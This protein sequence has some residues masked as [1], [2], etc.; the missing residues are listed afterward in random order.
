MSLNLAITGTGSAPKPKPLAGFDISS[1]LNPSPKPAPTS[2][3]FVGGVGALPSSTSSQTNFSGWLNQNTPKAN[4]TTPVKKVTTSSP[5][6]HTQTI[7][8]HAPQSNDTKTG[9]LGSGGS[10]TQNPG[11]TSQNGM[12]PTTPTTIPTT[13]PGLVGSLAK[14]STTPNA[15]YQ[16]YSTQAADA[17]KKA[18]EYGRQVAQAESD[19]QHNPNYSIDTGVGLAGQIAQN[20]GLKA[21]AL[22]QTAQGLGTLAN[23]GL[24]AKGQEISGLGTAAGLASPTLGSIGQVP[25]NP[26]SGG[27]GNILGSDSSGGLSSAA[28]LLGSFQGAQSTAANQ[29]QQIES[30]KSAHQQAQN[31]QSQL[32]DLI[33]TFGLNPS[34]I[35]AV[36]AGIQT[37]AKNTSSPQYKTLDNYL[38]DIASRYA[39]I[40]TPTGGSQ[41]DTTRAVATGMIDSLASGNSIIQVLN[42]LDQQAQAVISG[43][44]TSNLSGS[45][46]TEGQTASGGQ[47]VYKNGKWV[48][49]Q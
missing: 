18:A 25:F 3:P 24:T 17:Y 31:L 49:N 28:N 8:Y 23:Q 44:K 5:E 30:Y 21:A 26:L 4:P 11:G 35:N 47:L 14:T 2:S 15:Q 38:Q 13:F 6:G 22:T 42:T 39:Q 10:S 48:V 43:V 36:N 45:S 34:D 32:T 40:L 12:N 20:E 7:E 46:F 9:L 27:Q 37:I 1:V 16:D 33:T 19:V 41:T 29:Q